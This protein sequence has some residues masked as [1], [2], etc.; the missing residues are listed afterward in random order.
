[1]LLFIVHLK[2]LAFVQSPPSVD[3]TRCVISYSFLLTLA[4]KDQSIPTGDS[5]SVKKG[6][7][8]GVN[9]KLDGGKTKK[10]GN[11]GTKMPSGEGA[12]ESFGS[13]SRNGGSLGV[14]SN[15]AAR[16]GGGPIPHPKKH[17]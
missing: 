9:R 11:V 17:N 1:L 10:F 3:F 14:E 2:F 16:R 5:S 12:Q 4:V 13:S 15:K 8:Q 7:H 6:L